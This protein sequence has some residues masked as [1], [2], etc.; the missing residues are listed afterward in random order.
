[1]LCVII[2]RMTETILKTFFDHGRELTSGQAEQ[3]SQYAG[4]LLEWNA[5]MN[6]TA[7]TQPEE[8]VSKHFLDSVE[9]AQLI[10]SSA[11]AAD[12]GSGAGFPGIPLK[13]LRPD[14]DFT[15]M[16]SLN[17]RIGFLNEVIGRLDLKGCRAIHIRAEDAGTAPQHREQY[18]IVTAR[19]L[20]RLS[21]LCEY[22][23]PLVK[24]G[25]AFLAYKGL[26]NE[27]LQEA[28]RALELLGARHSRTHSY[29]LPGAAE[30][31]GILVLEKI[32][33]TPQGYPRGK[34]LERKSPL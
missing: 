31:R 32:K 16:D 29:T 22:A 18:Q 7:I 19:A 17:K 10:P 23:L 12:I 14:V 26:Y 6:L 2:M 5:R 9:G 30:H 3:L 1:M 25:G 33:P 11:R 21:T 27:E 28:G 15:L 4:L 34:G 20:A 13:I 8:I 24:P